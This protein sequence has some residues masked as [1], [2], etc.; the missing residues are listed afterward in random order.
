MSYRSAIWGKN[1]A[2]KS[3]R[4]AAESGYSQP[5]RHNS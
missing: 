3:F 4:F 1:S 5:E 2:H